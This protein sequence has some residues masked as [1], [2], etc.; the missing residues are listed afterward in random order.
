MFWS[1]THVRSRNRLTRACVVK[2][3]DHGKPSSRVP[4]SGP[5]V[6]DGPPCREV[7]NGA[8]RVAATT[9]RTWVPLL[10]QEPRCE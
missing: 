3:H 1:A 6:S 4:L 10:F 7:A 8:R 5:C 9:L 2:L